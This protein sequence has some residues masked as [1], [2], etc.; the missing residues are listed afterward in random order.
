MK[1]AMEHTNANQQAVLKHRT[2]FH[3]CY[4]YSACITISTAD[5]SI[6]CDP[7]FGDSAYYG[8]WGRYPQHEITRQFIGEFDAIWISH[9]HPDHYCPY[10]IEKI[11]EIY[12]YTFGPYMKRYYIF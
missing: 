2:D 10:S 7:W 3:V 5:I 9:I 8:T 11:M 4:K 1:Q 6:L 12:L